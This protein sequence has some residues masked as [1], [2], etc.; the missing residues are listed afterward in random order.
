MLFVL[1]QVVHLA[2]QLLD[3]VVLAVLLCLAVLH[4]DPD[5]GLR[6]RNL[7]AQL[8]VLVGVNL[9]VGRE[10]AAVLT[11]TLLTLLGLLGLPG[12]L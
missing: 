8:P 6:P 9:P 12:L 1:V 7:G 10:R 4:T 5:L 2:A 3:L 11:L